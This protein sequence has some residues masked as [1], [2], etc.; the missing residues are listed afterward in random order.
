MAADEQFQLRWIGPDQRE[1][2]L[3]DGWVLR[4]TGERDTQGRW[5]A[6]AIAL[7]AAADRAPAGGIGVAL[8]RAVPIG[9]ISAQAIAEIADEVEDIENQVYGHRDRL[10]AA[11]SKHPGPAGH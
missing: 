9:R 11:W 4:V 10:S 2:D 1:V 5:V 3:P 6:A 8:W 7:R